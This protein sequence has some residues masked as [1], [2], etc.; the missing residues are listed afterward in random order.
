[1]LFEINARKRKDAYLLIRKKVFPFVL[2]E[3]SGEVSD[4]IS[5]FIF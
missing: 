3:V 5:F 1:M 4:D 2:G